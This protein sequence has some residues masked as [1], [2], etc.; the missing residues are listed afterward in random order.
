MYITAILILGGISAVIL[1]LL[2]FRGPSATK[3]AKRRMGGGIGVSVHGSHRVVTE[4]AHRAQ[5]ASA[6]RDDLPPAS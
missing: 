3:A 2:A 4:H 5:H 6:V 1:L